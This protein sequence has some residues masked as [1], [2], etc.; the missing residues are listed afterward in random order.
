MAH[1]FHG[2]DSPAIGLSGGPGK[3]DGTKLRNSNA[4]G[5]IYHTSRTFL[6]FTGSCKPFSHH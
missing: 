3:H 2:F 5:D 6:H 4:P 1:L